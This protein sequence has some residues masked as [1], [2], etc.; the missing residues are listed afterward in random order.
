MAHR[1]DPAVFLLNLD[2]HKPGC[3]ARGEC[4]CKGHAG[5]AQ[6]VEHQLPKQA[7]TPVKSMS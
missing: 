2:V 5:V 6:P 3:K 4:Y 7:D 1:S